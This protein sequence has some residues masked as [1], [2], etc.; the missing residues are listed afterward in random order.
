MKNAIIYPKMYFDN[1]NV[2][3]GPINAQTGIILPFCGALQANNL[4]KPSR[5][6]SKIPGFSLAM[7]LWTVST[8]DAE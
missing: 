5:K 6:T 4:Q 2:R 8:S 3:L 7:S 1:P